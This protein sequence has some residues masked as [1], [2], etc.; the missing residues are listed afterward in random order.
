MKR[1]I[2]L[3]LLAVVLTGC[4]RNGEELDRAMGLRAKLLAAQSVRFDAVITADYADKLYTFAL[5]C[6]A[7]NQG[8]LQFTVLEPESIAGITGSLSSSSGKLTF[9]GEALAFDMMA[10]GL[11]SPVSGPWV[12]LKTLR[13]G[14]LTSCGME[15]GL[16]RVTIDDSYAED[17]LHLEVWLNGEDVPVRGEIIWQGI[18]ILSLEVK[19]FEIV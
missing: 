9:A 2:P 4:G 14:Y 16:L 17:A 15:D 10:E 19:N 1:L 6:T 8:N 3:L 18:R 5:G 11:V 7:D 12:L 13:S